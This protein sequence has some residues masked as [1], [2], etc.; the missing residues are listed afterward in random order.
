MGRERGTAAR[1]V[2]PKGLSCLVTLAGLNCAGSVSRKRTGVKAGQA[3]DEEPYCY[4]GRHESALLSRRP[5]RGHECR[6][7]CTRVWM[8]CAI[9]RDGGAMPGDMPGEPLAVLAANYQR[10]CG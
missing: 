7:Q 10:K 4:Q 8:N 5:W 3:R 1:L 9:A 2:A 6:R